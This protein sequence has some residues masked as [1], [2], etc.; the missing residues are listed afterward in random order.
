MV[1]YG[2]QLC[3]RLTL[4]CDLVSKGADL[5]HWCPLGDLLPFSTLILFSLP[6]H[7]LLLFVFLIFLFLSWLS[8][9]KK[10]DLIS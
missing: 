6:P 8:K 1:G 5:D 9:C 10:E 4:Y 2:F 7:P 3:P